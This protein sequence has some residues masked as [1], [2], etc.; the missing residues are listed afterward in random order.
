V[1][2]RAGAFLRVTNTGTLI[3]PDEAERLLEPFVRAEGSR[4]G[5]GLGLSIVRAIAAAH[6]GQLSIVA[7]PAGGLDIT[8]QFPTSE[9]H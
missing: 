3:A 2:T 9:K 7:R 1:S 6:R 8:V 4:A 5:A